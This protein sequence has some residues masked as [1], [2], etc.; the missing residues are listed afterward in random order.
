MYLNLLEVRDDS[1]VV[2]FSQL[3]GFLKY[4]IVI[5]CEMMLDFPCPW[6]PS[7]KHSL[8]FLIPF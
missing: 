8:E 1:Q 7:L 3:V 5:I 4:K 6:S 2:N